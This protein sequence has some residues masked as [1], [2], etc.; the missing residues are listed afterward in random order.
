MEQYLAP[1]T[2]FSAE[3]VEHLATEQYIHVLLGS[4]QANV[5]MSNM[6]SP[7]CILL[8]MDKL[9]LVLCDSKL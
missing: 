9:L 6:T 7:T 5:K 3:G 1:K 2:Q 8:G 4:G